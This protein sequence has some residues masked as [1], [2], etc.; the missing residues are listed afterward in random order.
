MDNPFDDRT[1]ILAHLPFTP[2]FQAA[3]ALTLVSTVGA[4]TEPAPKVIAVDGDD[5]LWS[6]TAGEIGST[7]VVFDEARLALAQRLAQ[8]RSAGTLLVL[9]TNNDADTVEAILDRSESPLRRDDFAA[10]STG[11]NA[12][13]ERLEEVARTLGLGL[14]TFCYLDDNPVEVARMRS[15]LPEVLSVTCPPAAELE[16]FLTRLWPMVPIA[17]TAEDRTRADFYRQDRERDRPGPQLNSRTSWRSWSSRSISI[18]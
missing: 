11:W 16:S 2:E 13:P 15:E 6:G 9:L 1:A 10:I 5:T 18:H 17:A 8:W 3:V 12:K 14:D 4:V 7:A